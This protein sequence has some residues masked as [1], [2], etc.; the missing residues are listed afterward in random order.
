M[1]VSAITWDKD[2]ESYNEETKTTHTNFDGKKAT[3]QMKDSYTLIAFLLIAVALLIADSIYCY[4]IK[5]R[6]KQKQFLTFHDTN[7]K[8]REV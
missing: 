1:D 6:V 4:L 2:I 3:C 8:L 7:N 5:Y